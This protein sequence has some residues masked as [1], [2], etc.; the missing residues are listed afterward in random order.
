MSLFLVPWRVEKP[1]Q[2]GLL[3]VLYRLRL[4][5]RRLRRRPRQLVPLELVTPQLPERPRQLDPQLEELKQL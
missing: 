1:L 5:I 4:V 2:V 3:P